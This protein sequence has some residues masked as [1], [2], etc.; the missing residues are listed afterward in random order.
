[1]TG[2]AKGNNNVG[3]ESWDGPQTMAKPEED[4]NKAENQEEWKRSKPS[5]ANG[6]KRQRSIKVWN[7]KLNLQAHKNK[8]YL[9]AFSLIEESSLSAASEERSQGAKAR[10]REDEN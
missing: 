6:K 1:L 10:R 4:K 7:K 9:V 5:E 3:P 2:Q 8:L